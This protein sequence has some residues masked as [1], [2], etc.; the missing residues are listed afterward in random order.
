M[1]STRM[2]ARYNRGRSRTSSGRRPRPVCHMDDTCSTNTRHTAARSVRVRRD[3]DGV[4]HDHLRRTADTDIDYPADSGR[5]AWV[6]VRTVLH[7]AVSLIAFLL[8]AGSLGAADAGSISDTQLIV[9]SIIAM[10]ALTWGVS[11][12]VYRDDDT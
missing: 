1:T 6:T 11:P 8:L 9:R 7:V 3:D 4:C 2:S 12:Y 5:D 10:V